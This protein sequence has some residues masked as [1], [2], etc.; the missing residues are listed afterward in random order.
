M[1]ERGMKILA[2]VH[3]WSRTS[4]MRQVLVEKLCDGFFVKVL[5]L[6][7]TLTHPPAKVSKAAE[8]SF[9]GRRCIATAAEILLVDTGI[10]RQRR[11]S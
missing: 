10:R 9:L 1:A 4:A 8:V 6:Q 3:D 11:S 7:S 5:R 2:R